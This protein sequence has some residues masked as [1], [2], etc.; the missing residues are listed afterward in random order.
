M[1]LGRDVVIK[2]KN[3]HLVHTALPI[4]QPETQLQLL[5]LLPQRTLHPPVLHLLQY[6]LRIDAPARRHTRPLVRLVGGHGMA[7][8]VLR[9]MKAAYV[10]V[11]QG[12]QFG[13]ESK[14]IPRPVDAPQ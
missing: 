6:A 3:L 12:I 5:D 1:P 14:R 11:D 7:V 8:H 2:L 9:A 13:P 4:L 10:Q